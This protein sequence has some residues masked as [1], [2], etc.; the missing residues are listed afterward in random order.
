[1]FV[2]ALALVDITVGCRGE[3]FPQGK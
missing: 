1:L 2:M 3:A